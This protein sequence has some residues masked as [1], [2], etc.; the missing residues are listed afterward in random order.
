MLYSFNPITG[1][2]TNQDSACLS[3]HVTQAT[4]SSLTDG[5]HQHILFLLDRNGVTHCYPEGC[6]LGNMAT[7]FMYTVDSS[8]NKIVGV[9]VQDN[10]AEATKM[11]NILLP[12]NEK[13]LAVVNKPRG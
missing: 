5:S 9:K 6:G 11:W 13:I 1:E 10:E 3:Y 4:V 8:T 2:L 12:E 7:T